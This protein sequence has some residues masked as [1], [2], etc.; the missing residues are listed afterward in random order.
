MSKSGRIENTQRKH[1]MTDAELR[2]A[3]DYSEGDI[4]LL[5]TYREKLIG[6]ITDIKLSH[7][8]KFLIYVVLTN[9]DRGVKYIQACTDQI[10]FLRHGD[11]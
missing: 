2:K 10:E 3:W 11:E 7:N 5:T 1:R 9:G 6:T 4:V 8:K